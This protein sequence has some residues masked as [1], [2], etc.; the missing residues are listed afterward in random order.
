MSKDVNETDIRIALGNANWT[1]P[2]PNQY[3]IYIGR[4]RMPDNCHYNSNLGNPFTVER[5]GRIKCIKLFDT[6]LEDE[7]LQDLV[8]L[9]RTK[10]KEG[11]NEFMLMCWCVPH[12]C[13]GSVIRK[14]LFELLKQEDLSEYCLYSGGA[15]GADSEF[16]YWCSQYNIE[17]KH[18]YCGEKSQTNAPNGNYPISHEDYLEGSMKVAEAANYLWNY[19][20][21]TMK[22]VRLI[23]NWAQVKYCDAVFAIGN[24]VEEGEPVTKS[25]TD[26]RRYI[27]EFVG[28]GTGYAVAM[29]LLAKKPIY[30]YEQNYKVWTVFNYEKNEFDVCKY[31]PKL[32]KNFAGIGSRVLTDAGKEAIHNLFTTTFGD[33]S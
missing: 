27:R 19:S 23:R 10:H 25:L 11:I 4:G 26:N 5:F 17:Q 1:K 24:L 2:E 31:T 7:M 15:Y 32:T 29:A 12:E 28:G 30:F 6:Y 9:I 22:D 14:R 33:L 18:Y 16:G 3:V 21:K 20:H 8:N 13:H